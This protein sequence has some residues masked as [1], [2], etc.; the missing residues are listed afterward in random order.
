MRTVGLDWDWFLKWS[1]TH[2]PQWWRLALKCKVAGWVVNCMIQRI[3]DSK[4]MRL[5]EKQ[6]QVGKILFP[7]TA[8]I[9]ITSYCNPSIVIV[10]PILP[11]GAGRLYL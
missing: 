9:M 8:G 4:G 10:F 5:R 11:Q 3:Y 2:L 6:G 1:D 7:R